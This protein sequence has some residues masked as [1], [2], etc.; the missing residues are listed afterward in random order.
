MRAT[1]PES[2]VVLRDLLEEWEG[3]DGFAEGA[4]TLDDVARSIRRWYRAWYVPGWDSGCWVTGTFVRLALKRV[5]WRWV[6]EALLRMLAR[7]QWLDEER[8][9]C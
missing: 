1:T 4:D 5:D 3:L 6:A 7:Q 9:H 2:R 8:R